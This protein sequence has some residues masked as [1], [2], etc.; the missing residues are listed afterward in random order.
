MLLA[1]EPSGD[2]LGAELVRALRRELGSPPDCFGVGGPELAAAGVDLQVDLTR[3]AVVGLVEVLKHYRPFKRIFDELVELAF[4]RRPDV[5][6]CVDF[7]GFNRRF[8]RKI[9]WE[10]GAR[11][12]RDWQPH[13]VQYVSPQVWASRPGRAR[14]MARD[15]DLVLAIFQIGRAH[16]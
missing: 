10:V 1:G 15:F 5:I 6:V 16:V 3:H 9:R 8:A 4:T 11:G 13:I 2:L 12:I 14:A 7:S